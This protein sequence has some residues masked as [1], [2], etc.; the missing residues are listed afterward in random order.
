MKRL[1]VDLKKPTLN[2][3]VI[4]TKLQMRTLVADQSRTSDF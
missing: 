3:I 1:K 2:H 4:H